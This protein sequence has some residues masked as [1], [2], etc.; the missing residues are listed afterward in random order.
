MKTLWIAIIVILVLLAGYFIFFNPAAPAPA[1]DTTTQTTPTT[2]T[3]TADQNQNP[4]GASVSYTDQGFSP[5]SVTISN[6]QTVTW[7]NNSSSS[8]WV[9]SDPHP[10]HSGYDGTSRQE[11]CATG[12]AGALPF[13]SCTAVPPGSSYT[14]T[15]TKAG[16]WGY[17]DH[18]ND[19]MSGTV[20]V[21][22]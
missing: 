19:G 16:S 8:L 21:T 14:F 18:L 10:Q 6:G 1:T 15:F 5:S 9:A 4:A 13:D 3:Q 2:D 12:Y 20:V 7:T 17:H 22:Q 11:H